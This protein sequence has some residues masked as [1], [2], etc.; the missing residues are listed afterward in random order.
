MSKVYLPPPPAKVVFVCI[1]IDGQNDNRATR[2]QEIGVAIYRPGME[3]VSL[4]F[5]FCSNQ[6]NPAR[7]TYPTLRIHGM[8]CFFNEAHVKA[9]GAE[10]PCFSSGIAGELACIKTIQELPICQGA[11]TIIWLHK[12][13]NC[14]K[15]LLEEAQVPEATIF[16]LEDINCPRIDQLPPAPFLQCGM[17]EPIFP[18]IGG[19]RSYPIFSLTPVPV[20]H[21]PRQETLSFLLWA[22]KQ[23]DFYL[24]FG[25]LL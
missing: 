4:S 3:K 20:Q 24:R 21:C 10:G 6:Q 11:T 25:K 1:D 19:T 8:P 7:P 16:N 17:H 15:S 13:G 14:E 12:G 2:A 9:S 5:Y 18:K 23:N 22:L